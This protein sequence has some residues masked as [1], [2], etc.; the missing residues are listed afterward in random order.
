MNQERMFELVRKLCEANALVIVNIAK[1]CN[2][3]PD[4]VAKF[5][6]ELMQSIL[7]KMEVSK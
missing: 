6:M 7:D 1:E 4:L 5:F 2:V 3:H